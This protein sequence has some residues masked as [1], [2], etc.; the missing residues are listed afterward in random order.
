M[1]TTFMYQRYKKYNDAYMVLTMNQSSLTFVCLSSTYSELQAGKG[2]HQ[3]ASVDHFLSLQDDLVFTRHIIQSLASIDPVI[4]YRGDPTSPGS[5]RESLKLA[6]DRKKNA[7]AWIKA[8]LASDLTLFSG[9]N[10]P[11]GTKNGV[12]GSAI[13]QGSNPRGVCL[14]SRHVNTSEIH[15]GLTAE[16]DGPPQWSKGRALHPALD[17]TNSLHNELRRWFLAFAE[18]FLDEVKRKTFSMES[19]SQVAEMMCQIKRVSEWLDV[20]VNEKIK[21]LEVG[22]EN[23]SPV[24]DSDLEAYG[25]LRNKIYVV[26]LKHVERTAT[27]LKI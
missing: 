14:E 18:N 22:S 11:K 25:R 20:M 23:S 8:A 16:K 19:D 12:K 1:A 13:T 21:T 7:T 26:L 3:Q 5:I 24:E 15:D 10:I 4:A 27:T 9:P 6:L 17:L 2:D